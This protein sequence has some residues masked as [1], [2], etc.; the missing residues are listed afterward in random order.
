M[1]TDS[2]RVMVLAPAMLRLDSWDLNQGHKSWDL[3]VSTNI[4]QATSAGQEFLPT[5]YPR[6]MDHQ[7][8]Q[9]IENMAI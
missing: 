3:L 9:L 1:V 8:Q 7:F 2:F 5:R 4:T 6:Q